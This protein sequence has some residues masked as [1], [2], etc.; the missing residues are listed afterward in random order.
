MEVKSLDVQ[1]V[2]E[3]FSSGRAVHLSKKVGSQ[4]LDSA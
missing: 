3:P 1:T 4:D 2:S